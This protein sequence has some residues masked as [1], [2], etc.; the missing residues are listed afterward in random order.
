MTDDKSRVFRFADFEVQE[1]EFVLVKADATVQVEPKAFR[2]LLFLLRNPGKLVTKDEILNAV[3]NDCSVSDNSLTKNIATL[4][5][6]LGD[7]SREPRYIA[8][9]QS[10]GYRFLCDVTVSED[11]S[12]GPGQTNSRGS[13]AISVPEPQPIPVITLSESANLVADRTVPVTPPPPLLRGWTKA[14]IVIGA[15]GVMVI[16]LAVI[17][18][19]RAK[20]PQ[21]IPVTESRLTANPHDLPVTSSAISPDAKYL[22]FTDRTGIYLR[23]V[24]GGEMQK[25]SL[26]EGFPPVYVES[27][28]PDSVHLVASSWTGAPA[29]P[30]S[31]WRVSVMGGTPRRISDDGSS[32]RVSPD[33]SQIAFLRALVDRDELWLMGPEGDAPRKIVGTADSHAEYLSPVAWS[34]DSKRVVYV[35]TSV[36]FSQRN[37]STIEILDLANGR[38]EQILS[39]PALAA[40]LAWTHQNSL[41]YSL[42]ENQPNETNVNLWRT[43]LDSGIVKDQRPGARIT[44]SRGFVVELSAT[45][46]GNLLALRRVDPQPD[47]YIAELKDDGSKMY[48]PSRLPRDKWGESVYSWTP[49]SKAILVVSERDGRQHIF[50]Q[51]I[52]RSEPELMVGGK[53]DY[54]IPKTNP[55]GSEML[56]FQMPGREE[57]P[58]D[59]RIMRVPLEGGR[60]QLVLQG[61]AIWYM[62]CARLPSTLC[63]YSSGPPH[64]VKFFSFDPKSG[65]SEQIMSSRLGD[66]GWPNWSLSA[67]GNYLALS[68]T[69]PGKAA[70]IRVLAISEN[71]EKMIS[72]PQWVD[73]AGMDW[74]ADNKSLWVSACVLHISDWGAPGP[75][76]LLK[77]AM[78]G[79]L[80]VLHE[81]GEV[82]YLAAIPSP[83]GKRLALAAESTDNSNVWLARNIP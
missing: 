53:G 77:V 33:G 74:A 59:I 4:R 83:D 49:D 42:R 32:A 19:I 5:R 64:Q 17:A 60:P 18:V 82:R 58:P 54:G 8:T 80:A 81:D 45:R 56:Y 39:N 44:N 15:L 48:S 43:Q 28:F 1:R 41:V 70:A 55:D 73:V 51:A 38:R 52:D 71:S 66:V 35:K 37:D 16:F 76:T 47:V 65:A 69:S 10:V 21:P 34:P 29:D 2:V 62:Q 23:Q 68:V 24:E 26:P 72:L 75:C 14:A 20:Q 9:V 63:V 67:D 61:R 7:D 30:K 31:L 57:A 13:I 6:L 46:D 11:A 50:R 25:L 40:P 3:W 27:W 12:T 78:N 79:K 36:Q 22:A